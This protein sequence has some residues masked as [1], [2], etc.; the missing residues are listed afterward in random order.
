M[1]VWLCVGFLLLC[2]VCV[3][4]CVSG[5]LFVRFLLLVGLYLCGLS[6]VGGVLFVR[7]F[8][9]WVAKVAIIH[10]YYDVSQSLNFSKINF[11]SNNEIAR[12]DRLKLIGVGPAAVR[13]QE[14]VNP[15]F[16]S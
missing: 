9:C 13:S 10:I 1:A 14:Q 2:G 6:I 8:Y 12:E 15:K 3:G 11:I 7:T 5:A 4:F 16:P